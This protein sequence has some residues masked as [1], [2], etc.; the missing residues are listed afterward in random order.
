MGVARFTLLSLALTALL[1]AAEWQRDGNAIWLQTPP[2][3]GAKGERIDFEWISPASFRFSRCASASCSLRPPRQPSPG[4]AFTFNQS[5]GGWQFRSSYLAVEWSQHTRALT[6]TATQSGEVLLRETPGEGALFRRRIAPGEQ[7]YGLGPRTSANLDLRGQTI[8]ATHPLLI[9]STGYGQF[10]TLPATPRFDLGEARHDEVRV[11]GA[12]PQLEYFFY[13]GPSPK[14]I[15]EEHRE[16]TGPLGPV[17]KAH[18]T[19][20]PERFLPPYAHRAPALPLADLIRYLSH[21]AMSGIAVPAVSNSGIDP[22]IAS[23]LP[24]VYGVAG[25]ARRP[26]VPYLLTYLEEARDR[27]IPMLRPMAMQYPADPDAA[28]ATGQFMLGDELLVAASGR[29]H[30]PRGIWTNLESNAV[31]K[32][33][34]SVESNPGDRFAHNGAIVPIAADSD[35]ILLH[36]FPRLGAEFFLPEAGVD[37]VTQIHAGPALDQL[38]LQVESKVARHYQWVVHHV[39]PA[40]K[41]DP[42]ARFRYDAG[43][44]NLYIDLAS[45]AGSDMVMN[46]T[47]E[48]PL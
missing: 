43:N 20:L 41:I 4:D 1:T 33:P 45:A 13:Y 35:R 18:V 10:F 46:V 3:N 29:V 16:I 9:S 25:A 21:A 27:G 31:R 19:V 32:G 40:L 12:G 42:P 24:I 26:W 11:D 28:A 22:A 15:L 14:N 8:A 44:R 7:L 17:S 23:V 47:L 30:L 39:S 36:Y 2:A 5:P 34:A 48:D 6:A 38:R 37:D